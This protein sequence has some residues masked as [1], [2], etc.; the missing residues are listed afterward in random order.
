MVLFVATLAPPMV[1]AQFSPC[2]GRISFLLITDFGKYY[3]FHNA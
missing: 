2:D 1:L 3:I